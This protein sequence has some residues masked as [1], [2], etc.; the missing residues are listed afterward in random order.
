MIRIDVIDTFGKFNFI[1]SINF[2]II[3][4]GGTLIVG[5]LLL[6]I[7]NELFKQFSNLLTSSKKK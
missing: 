1:A 4:A 5:Y 6:S 2:S 7:L 3:N